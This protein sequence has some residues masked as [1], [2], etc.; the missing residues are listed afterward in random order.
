MLLRARARSL[1]LLLCRRGVKKTISSRDIIVTVINIVEG[2]ICHIDRF[3]KT[4]EGV[5]IDSKPR[6]G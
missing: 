2:S 1:A 6:C 5:E 4:E 3:E